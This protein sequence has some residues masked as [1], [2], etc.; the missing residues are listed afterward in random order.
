MSEV[1]VETRTA[2]TFDPEAFALG[3]LVW[4]VLGAALIVGLVVAALR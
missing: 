4:L 2:K 1:A 3:R